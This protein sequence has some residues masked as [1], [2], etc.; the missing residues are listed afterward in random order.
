M[1]FSG[2]IY[3]L[4]ELGFGKFSAIIISLIKLTVPSSFSFPS[5]ISGET[6][7]TGLFLLM[8]SCDS[9]RLSAFFIYL[10][11]FLCSS[12][13][14]CCYFPGFFLLLNPICY[15]CS[16]LHFSSYA[17]YSAVPEFI[18][19]SCFL[20]VFTIYSSLINLSFFTY[21]FPDFMELS[22]WVFF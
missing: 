11:F 9:H 17:L 8:A 2:G 14:I 16:L 13:T 21:C 19:C 18:F 5:V 15:L 22:F 3:E 1:K 10:F 6:V 7:Y 20:F 4:Q 12:L